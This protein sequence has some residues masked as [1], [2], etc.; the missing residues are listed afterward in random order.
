[1]I[2]TKKGLGTYSMVTSKQER[3]LD[4]QREKNIHSEDVA[5]NPI[6]DSKGS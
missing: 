1:M 6:S 4:P 2:P 3:G 5:F